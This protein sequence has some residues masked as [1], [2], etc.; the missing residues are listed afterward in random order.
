MCG[1]TGIGFLYA[2]H[3]LLLSMAPV[4]GGGEMI[5]KVELQV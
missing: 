2:K 1:P 3:E 4:F 5:N